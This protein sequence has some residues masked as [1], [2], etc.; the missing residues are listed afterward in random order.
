LKNRLATV[1]RSSSERP[2]LQ[3]S[4]P[5]PEGKLLDS[6]EKNTKLLEAEPAASEVAES[7][8]V[9]T[10]D[11][12]LVGGIAWSAASK[13]SSQILTWAS[14]LIVARVLAPADFGL[15][16]MAAVYLGLA[17]KFSEFGF[18]TAIIT[19][20]DLTKEQIRQLNSF[21][22]LSGIVGFAVS[23][24][25]A[26]PLGWFFRAPR[27]PAVVVAMSLAFFLSGFQ[28]VPSSLLQKRLKFRSLSIIE[29]I[30]AVGQSVGT[31]VLA[32]SGFGY[33]ALV[34][35]SLFGVFVSTGLTVAVCPSGFA[36]P[37]YQSIQRA[38]KFSWEV[39]LARLAWNF[40]SDADFLVAGRVLGASA[41]GAYTFAW[42]LATMPIEKVSTLVGR[43][44]PAFFSAVQ[45]EDASLRRYLRTLT[46]SLALVTVP[47]TL[48]LALTAKEFVLLALGDKWTGA[49]A[50]TELLACY[51]SFRSLTTL[52][53]QVLT[54][55]HDTRFVMR[56][57]MMAVLLLPAAF[58]V[59]SR[60][61]TVGIAWAWII[62]Y[63]LIALPLYQRAFRRI[64]MPVREYIGAVRPALDGS[65]MMVV[66]VIGVK[67]CM[68]SS[69][70]LYVR[71]GLEVLSG[72]ATYAVVLVTF[73]QARLNAF[74]NMFRRLRTS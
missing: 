52:L 42:N 11:K 68:P 62:V 49:I 63:P 64:E 20:R 27:L 54:A 3:D 50:P 41:L 44:T 36:R 56:N 69:W 32:L 16:G 57:S 10:M 7:S 17:Q 73:Y 18:G 55:V 59:G 12:H 35:G 60:W 34:A 2:E 6:L 53:P 9:T 24:L 8:E 37:R 23:C 26:I 65:L 61:G 30:T 74:A 71:F 19:I 66:V 43:V 38:V 58:F 22:V 21:A 29:T 67:Y 31:L 70:P 51:A 13:W 1:R 48:G 28:T 46:E 40:Y 39:L 4:S 33:W 25:V 72:A 14:L 47:A 45:D 5:D 15:V